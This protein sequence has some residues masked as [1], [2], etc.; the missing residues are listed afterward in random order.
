[1]EKV[2]QGPATQKKAQP[3]PGK[4]PSIEDGQQ[5]GNVLDIFK[6]APQKTQPQPVPI[7]EGPS[8]HNSLQ[9]IFN[10]M[11]NKP[12][13]PPSQMDNVPRMTPNQILQ[14]IPHELVH[15]VMNL[16][17]T[18]WDFVQL[19]NSKHFSVFCVYFHTVL[20]IG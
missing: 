13:L 16:N 14:L 12:A 2:L 20:A 4:S 9:D 3:Q 17:I 19:V 15:L 6:Q 5:V 10:N 7:S 11:M 18:Q 1:M 8:R